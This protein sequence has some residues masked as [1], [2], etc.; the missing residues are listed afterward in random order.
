VESCG[1]ARINALLNLELGSTG[2]TPG[3]ACGNSEL[4][5]KGA[6]AVSIAGDL[7]AQVLFTFLGRIHE[8]S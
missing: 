5:R 8:G 7:V 1:W 6:V 2:D 4:P 3:E